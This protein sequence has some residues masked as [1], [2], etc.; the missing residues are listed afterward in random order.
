MNNSVGYAAPSSRPNRIV[1]G[2]DGIGADMIEVFRVAYLRQRETDVAATPETAWSW[3]AAG[4]EL[5]PEALQDRVTW[6]YEPMEPWHLAFT[7]GVRPLEIEVA[8]EV[9]FRGGR[10]TRVDPEEIRAKAREQKQRLFARLR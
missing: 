9:V 5:F 6:S 8:G 4:W 2:S 7:P 1:L 3:L 10:P